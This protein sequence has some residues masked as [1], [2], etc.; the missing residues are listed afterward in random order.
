[1]HLPESAGVESEGTAVH[2]FD[3]GLARGGI[4]GHGPLRSPARTGSAA[5]RAG[6]SVA[7]RAGPGH[8]PHPTVGGLHEVDPTRRRRQAARDAGDLRGRQ[9]Q[10]VHLDDPVRARGEGADTAGVVDVQADAGAPPG[11]VRGLLREDLAALREHRARAAHRRRRLLEA[12]E[13]LEGV[14]KHARLQLPLVR[15][16]DVPEIGAAGAQ[17]GVDL[18]VGGRPDV[19]ASVR[20]CVEDVDDGAAP[21][22]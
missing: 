22:G 11:R 10:I 17:V 1:M 8:H 12:A 5:G 3:D 18:H 9:G 21:E 13:P 7:E 20:R 15:Q 16:G 14:Q 2:L 4:L 6:A 19:R